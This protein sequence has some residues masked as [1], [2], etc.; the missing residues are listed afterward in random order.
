MPDPRST[1]TEVYDEMR[2]DRQEPSRRE[3]SMLMLNRVRGEI[4]DPR[5]PVT[6]LPAGQGTLA[7]D[8]NVTDIALLRELLKSRL[9]LDDQLVDMTGETIR[10]LQEKYNLRGEIEKEETLLL[11]L[12]THYPRKQESRFFA[13]RRGKMVAEARDSSSLASA[14]TPKRRTNPGYHVMS[15]SVDELKVFQL[16]GLLA[17]DAAELWDA[18]QNRGFPASARLR[19]LD[20]LIDRV[21]PADARLS[22]FIVEELERSDRGGEWRDGLLITTERVLVRDPELRAALK[23]NL[24]A[25]ARALRD[26]G[27]ARAKRSSG[28]QLAL[29][30]ALRRYATLVPAEETRSF[31][32]F[33]DDATPGQTHQVVFQC[34][35][36]VFSVEPPADGAP[37][38]ALRARVTALAGVY[39]R[40]RPLETG[41]QMSRATNSFVAAA[42]LGSEELERLEGLLLAQQESW[43]VDKVIEQLRVFTEA[44]NK[45]V[46]G[47]RTRAFNVASGSLTRLRARAQSSTR[48]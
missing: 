38:D 10:R 41:G 35:A 13:S 5:T 39:L 32:D 12:M 30:A 2:W 27:A 25:H 22:S 48:E 11:R 44:W 20:E 26:S 19:A 37:L 45:S 43:L 47:D 18:V 4:A 36:N 28:E 21:D 7:G 16:E 46:G 14:L 1:R 24:L 17:S 3:G 6:E 15:L 33:L 31:L 34:V 40:F 42:A 23:V 9:D 8:G 29:W